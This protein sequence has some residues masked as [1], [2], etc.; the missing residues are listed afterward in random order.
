MGDETGD[1]RFQIA[2]APRDGYG[3]NPDLLAM[4][5]HVPLFRGD[6]LTLVEEEVCLPDGRRFRMQIARHPGGAAVAAVDEG[7]RVC[8][9]RQYR[10]VAGGRLWELPAGKLDPNERPRA[11]ARRE[12]QEETGLRAA[13]WRPLGIVHSSPGVFSEVIHLFLATEL[14]AG[15]SARQ[16][17]ED[18]EVHW[19][20]LGRA[21]DWA[22]DGTITDAKTIAG[23]LRAH[24]ALQAGGPHRR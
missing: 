10:H 22:A 19:V 5:G 15:P 9:L 13:R 7:L 6:I 12:L 2:F 23:L 17:D 1:D 3:S 11:T 21:L 16:A 8:L 18:I 14:S 20:E 24:A 4:S